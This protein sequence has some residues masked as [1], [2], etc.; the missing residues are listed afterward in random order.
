MDELD[1][2]I[3]KEVDLIMGDLMTVDDNALD[4][5]WTAVPLGEDD[6]HWH[7]YPEYLDDGSLRY[8]VVTLNLRSGAR[9]V[10]ADALST[11]GFRDYWIAEA[12][13]DALC[14][15]TRELRPLCPVHSGKT[16]RI[17]VPEIQGDRLVWQCN[18]D[19]TVQCDLGSYWQWR[20]SVSP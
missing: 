7:T 9:V 8:I 14:D 13:Q 15:E 11:P 10:V 12:F 4:I 17:L 1:D 5:G 2:P 20:R 18:D 19:R 3:G 6:T 16:P